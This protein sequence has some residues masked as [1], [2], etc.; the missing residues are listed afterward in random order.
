M[1]PEAA[2][3]TFRL[4][5]GMSIAQAS[6]WHHAPVTLGSPALEV[7]TDLTR[8]KAATTHPGTALRQAEQ[9]MIYQ[10]VRMLFVTTEMPSIEGLITATDL[11]S[12]RPMRAVHDRNVRYDD[13]CVA[14]VMTGLSLLDAIDCEQMRAATVGNVISTLKA[15]GRNH[16]LVVEGATDSTPRRV[17]GV[18]SRSQI[19][20]QLGTPIDIAPIANSFSEIERALAER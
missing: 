18:V 5:P 3:T 2:L 20:R 12:D 10:G 4:E 19:E 15:L 1:N 7:M 9:L 6:P 11:R 8:V 16:L 13:L 17:R 14:D